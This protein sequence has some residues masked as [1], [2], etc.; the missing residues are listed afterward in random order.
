MTKE[1]IIATLIDDAEYDEKEVMEMS[2]YELLD[3]W[4]TWEG[5]I[6]YTGDIIE[7]VG[8][9]YNVELEEE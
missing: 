7:A 8:E 6:G 5:I 3:K 4:L 2:P 1:D 9:V